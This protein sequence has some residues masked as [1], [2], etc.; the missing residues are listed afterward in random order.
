MPKDSPSLEEQLTEQI[1]KIYQKVV[2]Q[3]ARLY[4]EEVMKDNPKQGKKA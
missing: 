2:P 4:I 1:E 3:P